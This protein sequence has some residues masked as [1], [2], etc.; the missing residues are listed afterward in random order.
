MVETFKAG[1][2]LMYALLVAALVAMAVIF[3][4]LVVL[5][6]MPSDKKA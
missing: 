2:P 3:E 1:G 5:H 4:R 6:R